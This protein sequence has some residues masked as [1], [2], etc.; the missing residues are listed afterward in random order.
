MNIERLPIQSGLLPEFAGALAAALLCSVALI[1]H[2]Q[3]TAPAAPPPAAP[4]VAVGA[5]G[6][7]LLAPER[8]T[9]LADPET[10]TYS[11]CATGGEQQA[12]DRGYERPP[13]AMVIAE[14]EAKRRGYRAGAH[15]VACK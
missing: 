8:S 15:K 9:V 11:L 3:T 14:E 10:R 5:D 13:K 2:A 1:A 4:T 6:K 7:P 12:A